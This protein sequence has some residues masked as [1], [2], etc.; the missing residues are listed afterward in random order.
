MTDSNVAESTRD[1]DG[2]FN[3][4]LVRFF[5][6]RVLQILRAGPSGGMIAGFALFQGSSLS[7][8]IFAFIIIIIACS[9][10]SIQRVLQPIAAVLFLIGLIFWL[11][12]EL[13]SIFRQAVA[14]AS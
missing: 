14:K 10:A 13:V 11:D 1:D 2:I 7:R 9:V 4:Q 8:A 6:K 5:T 12:G 3:P